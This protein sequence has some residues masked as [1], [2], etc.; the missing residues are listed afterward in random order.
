MGE[1]KAAG[2]PEAIRGVDPRLGFPGRQSPAWCEQ[3]RSEFW[4]VHLSPHGHVGA[5]LPETRK[6]VSEYHNSP[7]E[8][9]ASV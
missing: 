5:G 2:E 8:A 9:P 4:R 1:Q 3:V 6:R 7:G